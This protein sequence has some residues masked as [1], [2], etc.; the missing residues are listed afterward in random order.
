M[1]SQPNLPKN[2]RLPR[3]CVAIYILTAVSAGLYLAFTQSAAF[4]DWFNQNIST[5]G[6]HLLATLTAWLP[7]SLAE[8]MICLLPFLLVLLIVL[9]YKHYCDTTR[10]MFVY[11]GILISGLCVM[12]IIFVWN[13]AAGY[14]GSTL[15]QKL[16]LSREKSSADDLYQTAE[17]LRAELDELEKEVVFLEDG[18]SLMPYSYDEMNAKLTD[19]Y[20]RFCE[21]YDFMDTYTCRV[22]PIMLSEPMSYT[23]ITGVYSFFTGEANIN[24]NFPDYTVP[25]T[26]AHELAHQRGIAREDEAN[27]IAFLVC[28]ESDD[29]YIRYSGCLNVYEYV[30]SALRSADAKLYRRSYE[31]LPAA[32]KQEEV[33]YALFFEQY[34]ENVSANVSQAVN[35]TYL[36]SQGASA[37]TRS[38]SMVVDLAV[39]YYRPQFTPTQP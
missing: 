14:Y 4:S 32:I 18:T 5:H 19:A 17:F 2:K 10:E 8:A 37:G 16:G 33:A 11:I 25:Y 7:F 29:P 12:G 28:M 34:R 26:A 15:D 36:Q 31:K 38:Y 20:E 23:H 24:V 21:K 3:V 22:K 27:F 13:F 39:A 6:R 9:G 35:N 30:S 1:T